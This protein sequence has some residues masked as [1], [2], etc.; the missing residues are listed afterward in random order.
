MA[1]QGAT[2]DSGDLAS[3]W[4]LRLITSGP[5]EGRAADGDPAPIPRGDQGDVPGALGSM[6][7]G[8]PALRG[9]LAAGGR[10]GIPLV[11]V[12]FLEQPGRTPPLSLHPP[13]IVPPGPDGRLSSL[14]RF[15]C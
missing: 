5:A 4:L 9:R 10:I 14:C 11:P 7:A 13:G 1:I 6:S 3:S 2:P 15:L 12:G 8:G